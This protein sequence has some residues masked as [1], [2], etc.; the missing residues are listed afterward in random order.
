MIKSA[1]EHTNG[2]HYIFWSARC[3]EL[4]VTTSKCRNMFKNV[5]ISPMMKLKKKNDLQISCLL[6]MRSEFFFSPKQDR[7]WP[8]HSRH[9]HW[10][11][12]NV[13]LFKCYRF[14]NQNSSAE[15][16]MPTYLFCT[17]FVF[18]LW[19]LCNII[20]CASIP[21]KPCKGTVSAN[22]LY[23]KSPKEM[24]VCTKRN[25]LM[26]CPSFSSSWHRHSYNYLIR[27]N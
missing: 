20:N 22:L 11:F 24:C 2:I 18:A 7:N 3:P 23:I 4:Q 27:G 15:S 9:C 12:E 6:I 21:K 8:L 17:F 14:L 10:K 26:I 16:W 5:R 25:L 13:I 1:L 19:K